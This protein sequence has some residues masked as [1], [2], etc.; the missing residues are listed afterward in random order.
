MPD[1]DGLKVCPRL[2]LHRP[3]DRFIRPGW[4]HVISPS[5]GIVHWNHRLPANRKKTGQMLQYNTLLT[6]RRAEVSVC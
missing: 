2:Q 1:Q 5:T 4:S 3:S 6:F